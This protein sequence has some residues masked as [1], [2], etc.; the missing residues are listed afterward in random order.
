MNFIFNKILNKNK[1]FFLLKNIN[2]INLYDK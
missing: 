1:I 2:K